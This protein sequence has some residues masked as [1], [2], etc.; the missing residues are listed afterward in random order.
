MPKAVT[1]QI[2]D[3][4]V[5][6]DIQHPVHEWISRAGFPWGSIHLHKNSHGVVVPLLTL[7]WIL[8][9]KLIL[10]RL[11]Q[12]V[13]TQRVILSFLHV[14]VSIQMVFMILCHVYYNVFLLRVTIYIF[15][16]VTQGRKQLIVQLRQQ[17]INVSVF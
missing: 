14:G 6:K 2:I 7:S 1:F 4:S 9:L 10:N 13:H 3:F 17:I 11:E 5:C 12:C 15:W 16:Q 8:K